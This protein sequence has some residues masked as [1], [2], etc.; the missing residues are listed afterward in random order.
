MVK[1]RIN[2]FDCILFY[3]ERITPDK[4]PA[5]HSYMY[6]VRHDED[7]WTYPIS[8][9]HFVLVNFFGTIFTKEPIEIDRDYYL[10][11]EHF[12]MEHDYV[13]FKIDGTLFEKMLGL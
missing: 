5:G 4:A 13:K 3:D 8:V 12:E 7:D 10:E 1:A 9:E 11:I 6:H 2:G